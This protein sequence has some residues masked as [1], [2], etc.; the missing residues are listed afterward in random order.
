MGAIEARWERDGGRDRKSMSELLRKV[1]D[2]AADFPQGEHR[3]AR[4]LLAE[5]ESSDS[6]LS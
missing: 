6:G 1:F 3:F 2:R 5:L 4:L